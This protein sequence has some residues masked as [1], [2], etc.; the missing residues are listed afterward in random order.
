MEHTMNLIAA[1]D[2]NWGIGKD[3]DLLVHLKKD[4][5]YFKEKTT[6]H[7]IVMGR[8]TLESFPGGRPLKNRTNII[9]SRDPFYH[10]EGAM[11]VGSTEDLL[12]C[13]KNERDRE[14]WLVGGGSLYKALLPWCSRAYITEL[15]AAYPADTFMPNL[16]DE[17]GWVLESRGERMEE[18]GIGFRFCIYKNTRVRNICVS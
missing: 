14:V 17:Q 2:R 11:V 4:M 7:V 13:L 12:A 9:L 16:K 5:N 15:E 6:G 8:K 18:K 1:A 10:V 3:G